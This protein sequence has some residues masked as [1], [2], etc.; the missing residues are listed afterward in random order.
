MIIKNQIK[1]SAPALVRYCQT[2][3]LHLSLDCLGKHIIHSTSQIVI[4][5]HNVWRLY[6][7]SL[8]ILPLPET[9]PVSEMHSP[10]CPHYGKIL[11]LTAEDYTF[12]PTTYIPHIG[13]W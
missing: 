11:R 7:P 9:Y 3:R 5:G 1:N 4:Y 6:I 13:Q 10:S 2:D 12:N 8:Y